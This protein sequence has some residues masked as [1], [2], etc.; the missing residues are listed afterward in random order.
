MTDL[1]RSK[2]ILSLV[3]MV[4]VFMVLLP[5]LPNATVNAQGIEG[6]PA[7]YSVDESEVFAVMDNAEIQANAREYILKQ[8]A[9]ETV[10][11]QNGETIEETPEDTLAKEGS[12][13]TEGTTY[14]LQ[15][16]IYD[17]IDTLQIPAGSNRIKKELLEL[18]TGKELVR[19]IDVDCADE[20]CEGCQVLI[21][22]DPETN[23]LWWIG[24]NRSQQDHNVTFQMT[25]NDQ[26]TVALKDLPSTVVHLEQKEGVLDAEFRALQFEA[27]QALE[28]LKTTE[29]IADGVT[30]TTHD[31]NV[32]RVEEVAAGSDEPILAGNSVYIQ[33]IPAKAWMTNAPESETEEPTEEESPAEEP[34]K[35]NLDNDILDDLIEQPQHMMPMNQQL[36][37]GTGFA[38]LAAQATLTGTKTAAKVANTGS[39]EIFKIQVDIAGTPSQT[40]VGYNDADIV[41]V[42]DLS[43][44]MNDYTGSGT[45][46]GR[47]WAKTR[48]ALDALADNLI[49]SGRANEMC[50][51]GYGNQKNG[52]TGMVHKSAHFVYSGFT[53]SPAAFK[54]M[55]AGSDMDV[56]VIRERSNTIGDGGTNCHA[57]F[58]GAKE[59][60]ATRN[61]NRNKFIIFLSDGAASHY[62][63]KS[64]PPYTEA[65]DVYGYTSVDAAVD[66]ANRLKAAGVQIFTIGMDISGIQSTVDRANTLLKGAAS[67]GK[68]YMISTV[69][70]GNIFNTIASTIRYTTTTKEH[71]SVQ[72]VDNMSQYV[73]Y[74]PSQNGGPKLQ[75]SSNNG[76]TWSD[77]AS[78]QLSYSN[79]GNGKL[80]WNIGSFS[81]SK[82]YRLTYY[83]K[84]KPEHYGKK[85]HQNPTWGS[86]PTAGS[87]GVVANGYT[88]VQSS[89][90]SANE[91]RVPTVY[92]DAVTTITEQGT[93]KGQKTAVETDTPGRFTVTLDIDGTKQKN[94]TGSTITYKDHGTVKLTDPMSKYVTYAGNIKLYVANVGSN[95]WSA[96]SPFNSAIYNAT[97]NTL[98][99][100]IAGFSSDKK[101]R[102]TYEV[103][104]LPSYY[105]IKWHKNQTSGLV[106]VTG[107]DGVVANGYTYLTSDLVTTKKE[108]LVPTVYTPGATISGGSLGGQKTAFSANDPSNPG[109]FNVR[110]EIEGEKLKEVVDSVETFTDHGTVKLTDPMSQYVDYAGD[111]RVEVA[112]K[113]SYDWQAYTPD[114]ASSYDD[115]TKTITWSIANFSSDKRYRL[116]YQ[117]DMLPEHYGKHEHKDQSSGLSPRAGTDGMVANGYTYLTSDIITGKKEVMVPTV[118]VPTTQTVTPATFDGHKFAEPVSGSNGKFNITVTL[119]SEKEKT[120]NGPNVSFQDHEQVYLEDPLSVYVSYAGE[121]KVEVA[122]RGTQNW[123][124]YTPAPTEA[125]LFDQA[126]STFRWTIPNYSSDKK[127][128]LSYQVK[129]K[130]EYYGMKVHADQTSGNT[131]AAGQD[132][133]VANGYT[134]VSSPLVPVHEIMVPT[135][136]AKDSSHIAAEL[137]GKK[138][139]T[140]VE[141]EMDLYKVDLKF[142]GSKG[143]IIDISNP[144][145]VVMVVDLSKSMDQYPERWTATQASLSRAADALLGSQAGH[146]MAL[147]G[148]SSVGSGLQAQVVYKSFTSSAGTFKGAYESK[149]TASSMRG[150]FLKGLENNCEAGFMGAKQLLDARVGNGKQKIV[151]FMTDG[152]PTRY[153]TK[154]TYPYVDTSDIPLAPTSLNV[155][156]VLKPITV[157]EG[158][159]QQ[160]VTIY[161]VGLEIPDE[162][163]E[164]ARA[165]AVLQVCATP[166]LS[167]SIKLEN[168][169]SLYLELANKIRYTEVEQTNVTVT[170]PMSEYVVFDSSRGIQAEESSDDGNTWSY[171]GG[172]SPVFA[173]DT[174]TWTIP[175]LSSSKQYRFSYY[176]RV[177]PEYYWQK[178][179]QDQ[180]S[181]KNPA[182]GED[183]VVANGY[184]RITSDL[185][186]EAKEIMVPT[187]YGRSND[188]VEA[189]L[190]GQKHATTI[191]DQ[192]NLHKIELEV[193]GTPSSGGGMGRDLDIVVVTS[194]ADCMDAE[195]GRWDAM[196]RALDGFAD[197]LLGSNQGHRM[198]LVG[199]ASQGGN[200]GQPAHHVYRDFTSDLNAFKSVY[201]MPSAASMRGTIIRGG[202]VNAH[203]GMVGAKE[204]L[205]PLGDNGR[206]KVVLFLET[207]APTHYYLSSTNGYI[208]GPAD[209]A[210]L[211]EIYSTNTVADQLKGIGTLIYS[212]GLKVSDDP[213]D[214]A[215]MNFLLEMTA[216]GDKYGITE[217]ERLE[218][219]YSLL[220]RRIQAAAFDHKYVIVTDPMSEH[221]TYYEPNHIQA[222]V[223]HDDGQTWENY[224]GLPPTYANEENGQI[225][226]TISPFSSE[227]RYRLIY[228]VKIKEDH[229]GQKIHKDGTSGLMPEPG[230]D[231]VVAN[232]YTRVQSNLVEPQEIMVPTVFYDA[233]MTIL[234]VKSVPLEHGL[235]NETFKFTLTGPGGYESEMVILPEMITLG[236]TEQ[237]EFDAPP[238]GFKSG[239]YTISESFEKSDTKFE[240]ENIEVSVD[241]EQAATTPGNTVSFD[242][243]AGT[244]YMQIIAKNRVKATE[245]DIDESNVEVVK[246]VSEDEL[247]NINFVI[248]LV[249]DDPA[250]RDKYTVVVPLRTVNQIAASGALSGILYNTPY[251]VEEEGADEVYEVDYIIGGKN[252]NEFMVTDDAKDFQIHV[253]N[254]VLRGEPFS[255]TKVSAATDK[256]LPGA[257]F[258]LYYCPQKHTH[259]EVVSE[260]VLN[261]QNCWQPALYKGQ[262]VDR[263]SDEDGLVNLGRLR[264][265]DYALV[266]TEA[267]TGYEKPLGQWR[268]HV[269]STKTPIIKFSTAGPAVPPAFKIDTNA[270]YLPNLSSIDLPE[271]GGKGIAIFAILGCLIIA[272]A[273]FLII[274][275][276]VKN[277]KH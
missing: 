72:L 7:M 143:S 204:L 276:R 162:P 248:K 78:N 57:G 114:S 249:P 109:R 161:T 98:N 231:G 28:L 128:R 41:V 270:Y 271:N 202:E 120:Q 124:P 123:I 258:S 71:T 171:Y 225:S 157:A 112:D 141:D 238:L 261:A 100:S 87:A 4:L 277:V 110:L 26:S 245:P 187:V 244:R 252:T 63:T 96:Y 206:Q 108:V 39:D 155:G 118:Y 168:M 267:P 172:A 42:V 31:V 165:N 37:S 212:L 64:T 255:F 73:T 232:G 127:Y 183:G 18:L 242:V 92:A 181:G 17:L 198:A 35:I 54:V 32:M 182:P 265:G 176:V 12:E 14:L 21:V 191:E 159:K 218:Y 214:N 115:Q 269:D 167:H 67:P 15:S 23:A 16:A 236:R 107:S 257:S 275:M 62:Y 117:V 45:D 65:A 144:A 125:E 66:E 151:I 47:R 195:S 13:E 164:K 33:S 211:A 264:D 30:I 61:N 209:P 138:R 48:V 170:D 199:Y 220:A 219:A 227:F 20:N 145:D 192:K 77:V 6:Q 82:R 29:Y 24:L 46:R 9:P 19:T 210:T 186:P 266:E 70:L 93:L 99:W 260:T 116:S 173:D 228:Y 135:V 133:V 122:D 254:K 251:H 194:L 59:I 190:G 150:N 205:A 146:E 101:Y 213:V 88:Y 142:S 111:M 207:G 119:L 79:T 74:L 68:N 163:M 131:P 69:D 241:F 75:V 94:Q 148:Y 237:L 149:G 25:K 175:E 166:G 179:H 272:G 140:L 169:E 80:T 83:V 235:P 229:L 27:D 250:L 256:A 53:S 81:S 196:K 253:Y 273:C 274:R 55:Y 147:V 226:W 91:L 222:Q 234:F 126:T 263:V 40:T 153:Y 174:L 11:I 52:Q 84:L 130:P 221:V 22:L 239:T 184:T 8:N 129:I 44:S 246:H 1:S 158:L 5:I 97:T 177:K 233:D 50:M 268:L 180:T 105:G 49:G 152:G 58:V 240:T 203:A 104:Q 217:T 121:L 136:F 200:I 223:S 10:I 90:V 197:S 216:S 178:L 201:Q 230:E 43:G 34:G 193:T 132:G 189:T 95:S 2:K 208:E 106:P 56:G 51:I 262:P 76:S 38:T 89:L 160:G 224:R 185:V 85:L 103:D 3:L 259:E 156:D 154:T 113:N 36:M 139:A 247:E 243:P 86:N 60:L 215:S 188:L 134:Y 137:S 102:V